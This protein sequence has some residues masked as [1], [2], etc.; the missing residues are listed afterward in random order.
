MLGLA[1]FDGRGLPQ[2]SIMGYMWLS[3]AVNNGQAL[4]AEHLDTVAK[5][6]IPADV[7]K[8]QRLAREWLEKHPR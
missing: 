1:Y 2:D 7:S 4:A 8:A 5:K 3:I 6:M